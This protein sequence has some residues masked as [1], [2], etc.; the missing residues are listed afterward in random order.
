MTLAL[1]VAKRLDRRALGPASVPLRGGGREPD[2]S[3]WRE[4]PQGERRG[5]FSFV[6]QSSANDTNVSQRRKTY[7]FV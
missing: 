5:R 1:I 6:V 2:H 3:T 4:M 7:I